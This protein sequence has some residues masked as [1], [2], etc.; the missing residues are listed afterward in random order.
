MAIKYMYI[1]D[2]PDKANGIEAGLS[3]TDRLKVT[4]YA[5][6][7]WNDQ[8]R[9]IQAERPNFDG[10][11]L[12]LQLRL[13]EGTLLYDAPALAQQLRNLAKEGKFDDLPIILC[14]TD[15]LFLQVYDKSTNDDLFD[16]IYYKDNWTPV[17]SNQDLLE[18]SSLSDGYKKIKNAQTGDIGKLLC[19]N[20]DPA[21][22][23][24]TDKLPESKTIHSIASFILKQLVLKTGLLVDE[25]ILAI[26]LG[27]DKENSSAWGEV[28]AQ[29]TQF[30]YRGIF[31]EAWPRWWIGDIMK[32]W[33]AVSGGGSL[34][35]MSAK[36]K[37][38]I[39]KNKLKLENLTS[40]V[41]PYKHNQDTFWY[42]CVITGIPLS[43]EDGL[44]VKNQD[45][46]FDWQDK[47]YISMSHLWTADSKNAED[48][49]LSKIAFTD[50][51]KVKTI[52]QLKRQQ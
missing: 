49:I 1:D 34:R 43:S 41:L 32:W 27:F 40:I 45:S 33:R 51:D 23:Q 10:L 8:I 9:L 6:E 50:I 12:D 35:N 30:Q 17:V 4:L 47:E 13:P 21:I 25:D 29:L 15:D 36:E 39:L 19:I 31:H 44:L 28:K 46:K 7:N 20:S 3:A 14:T 26:R 2:Q 16:R 22:L 18:F 52:F 5:A 37:V 24:L 38:D 48:K 11:L 42:K